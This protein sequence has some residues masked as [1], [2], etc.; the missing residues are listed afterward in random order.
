MNLSASRSHSV[1]PA[2]AFSHSLALSWRRCKHVAWRCRNRFRKCSQ[3]SGGAKSSRVSDFGFRVSGFRFR[4][5]GFDFR[6]SGFGFRFSGF[7]FAVSGLRFATWG[8]VS[9]FGFGS[10]VGKESFKSPDPE[11]GTGCRCKSLKVFKLHSTQGPSNLNQSQHQIFSQLVAI[12][13]HN[14]A[15][16]MVTAPRT[17]SPRDNPRKAFCGFP[18]DSGCRGE[19]FINLQTRPL[20]ANEGDRKT[21]R[22]LARNHPAGWK[23]Q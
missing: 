9:S 22:A 13:A 10:R 6:V 7:G 16:R 1:S 11:S 19:R 8:M 5:L 2:L 4:I 21:R 20:H 15:P 23:S 18:L 3:W 17:P 14:M 12:N